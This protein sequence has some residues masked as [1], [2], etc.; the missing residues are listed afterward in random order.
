MRIIIALFIAGIFFCCKKKKQEVQQPSTAST[1]QFFVPVLSK[2]INLSNWFNDYSDPLQYSTRFTAAAM[3]NI[4]SLGFT[5]VRM[6]I[7]NTILFDA[8]NPSQLNSANLS[9]VDAGVK[10]AIDAG[11]GITINIHPWKNDMD[12][13]LA[14][15]AA[16]VTKVAAYWKAMAA[17]FKKYPAD[18]L[19]FE[20][21]NEPHASATGLT[22]QPKTWWQNV[23]QQFIAAI[24]T[25]TTDHYVI[26]GGEEWNSINGLV[27]LQPYAFP[28]V[29]YNFHFYDPFLFTHQGASWAGW[30]PALL[31]RNIPYPSSPESVTSLVNAATS[32]NLKDALSWYGSQRYNSDSLD[33][34]VKRA[35]SWATV[36]N[37]LLICN[38]FGS[39]KPFAPRQSRLAYIKDVRTVLERNKIGW[40][41]W[42]YDEGFGLI[43]YTGGNRNNPLTDAELAAAL[44][45]R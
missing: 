38:E 41:M 29:I 19:F 6:P 35:A 13:V 12:S 24:R 37:V 33:R 40:A 42:E 32:Q 9:K 10:S 39:Y 21:Y 20:V 3:Q 27:L 14:A 18:K 7:G 44:G 1:F 16:T 17:F 11:L 23:Q 43:D 45:L 31:G 4:K 36:N 15:D 8:A 26:A 5:Y 28:K 2:G 34:W 25:E 30:E 22:T